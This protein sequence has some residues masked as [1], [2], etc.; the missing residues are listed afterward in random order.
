MKGV[1]L[2]IN[3]LL[4]LRGVGGGLKEMGSFFLEGGGVFNLAKVMVSIF[5]KEL[6]CRVEKLRH[7]KLQV[8]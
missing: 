8:M 4:H 3:P 1:N 2:T 7:E 6:E 5:H